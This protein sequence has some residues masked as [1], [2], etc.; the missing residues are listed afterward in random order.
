M[1]RLRAIGCAVL[2]LVVGGGAWLLGMDAAHSAGLGAVVAGLCLCLAMLG[3]QPAVAWP[4]PPDPIRPGSRRDVAQLGWS[5]GVRG[6]P[7]SPEAVRRLRD[8]AEQVLER[9]GLRLDDPA[10]TEAVAGLLGPGAGAVLRRGSG[11]RPRT[12][13]FAAVLGRLEGLA[14]RDDGRPT[15]SSP[16]ALVSSIATPARQSTPTTPEEPRNAH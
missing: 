1:S 16:P 12:A 4:P 13:D 14:G 15:A 5:L 6:R 2:G 7:V 9:D 10:D 8:L 3:E 11:A